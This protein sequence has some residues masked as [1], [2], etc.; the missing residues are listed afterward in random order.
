VKCRY[1]SCR[2]S[3]QASKYLIVVSARSRSHSSHRRFPTKPARFS[4]CSQRTKRGLHCGVDLIDRKDDMNRPCDLTSRRLDASDVALPFETGAPLDT[5]VDIIASFRRSGCDRGTSCGRAELLEDLR[6]RNGGEV[7]AIQ[8]L[9][10]TQREPTAA[11][12]RLF[13]LYMSGERRGSRFVRDLL[14]ECRSFRWGFGWALST[15]IAT[16]DDAHK[17]CRCCR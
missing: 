3:F 6:A 1:R 8:E 2:A 12:S 14:R 7:P 17:R 10:E 15:R 11:V 4:G 5:E 9:E 16:A 13:D